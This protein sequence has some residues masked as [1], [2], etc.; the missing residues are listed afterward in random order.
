MRFFAPNKSLS[1]L[2]AYTALPIISLLLQFKIANAKGNDEERFIPIRGTVTSSAD[3]QPLQGVSVTI[4]GTNTGTA[5]DAG[6]NFSFANVDGNATLVFSFVGYQSMEVPVRN[7]TVIDIT[8]QLETG[9]LIETVVTAIAIRRD[10]R[11]LGYSAPVVKS[12]ELL[13]GR[14]TSPLNALQG[15]V[16]GVNITSTAS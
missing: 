11:S 3:Q 2:I 6:G 14:N 7:R 8:L 5:T 12:D 16:A 9:T 13:S 4:K 15:K 1:W 10:K